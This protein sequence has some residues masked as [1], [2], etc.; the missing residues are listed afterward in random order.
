MTFNR[1]SGFSPSGSCNRGGG[2]AGMA[3]EADD[4]E[5]AAARLEA[6]LERIARLA[7]TAAGYRP[8]AQRTAWGQVARSRR[9][10]SMRLPPDSTG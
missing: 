6:A 3:G 10:R 8:A 1:L 5:D 9:Y 2:F 7:G 4:P